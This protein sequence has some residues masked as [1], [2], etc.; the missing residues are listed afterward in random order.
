MKNIKKI[1]LL[2]LVS[3]TSYSVANATILVDKNISENEVLNAQTAWCGALIDISNTYEENGLAKAQELAVAVI[4]NAYG[5]DEGVVLFK[6]TLSTSPQTF[7]LTAEGALAYFVGGN[8]DYPND[9]G[10]A[11]KGWKDCK[12]ENEAIYISGNLASTMGKV[13]LLDKDGNKTTV[14]KTWQFRKNDSDQIKIITH[15]SSLEHQYK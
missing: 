3:F 9:E 1:L 13:H 2:S 15:H 5:Y 12:P 4:D 14:D 10:F 7:R 11:L 6:P 8:K